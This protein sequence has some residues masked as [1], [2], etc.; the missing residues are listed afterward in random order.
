MPKQSSGNLLQQQN[1]ISTYDKHLFASNEA[2]SL[3]QIHYSLMMSFI[4]LAN[5]PGNFDQ[6][7]STLLNT[8]IW[9]LILDVDMRIAIRTEIDV[10][11]LAHGA[12]Y[13]KARVFCERC[14]T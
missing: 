6:N 10:K 9:T 4:I 13:F 5:I 8:P 1:N 3:I 14:V 7:I 11:S 12:N 2:L